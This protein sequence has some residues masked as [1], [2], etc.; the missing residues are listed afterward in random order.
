MST[1]SH[2]VLV[3]VVL[4]ADPRKSTIDIIQSVGRGQRLYQRQTKCTVIVPIHYNNLGNEHNFSPII[5]ILTAMNDF[6]GKIVE[7]FSLEERNTKVVVRKM[8]VNRIVKCSSVKMDKVKYSVSDMINNLKT[9]IMDR[10]QLSWEIKKNL[11]FKY[12][13]ENNKTPCK[14][15][16]YE[17]TRLGKWVCTQKSKITSSEDD[18][19]KELSVNSIVK[20][21]LDKYLQHKK[22]N[23]V[24]IKI[25]WNTKK[26][27]LFQYCN[28]EGKIPMRCTVYK[29]IKLGSWLDSQKMKITSS[30]D[31]LYKILSVNKFVKESLDNF[32]DPMRVWNTK[33]EQL[34]QYCNKEGKIPMRY[35]VYEDTRLGPWLDAQK[36]K[37]TSSED[38]LYKILST[39]DIVKECLD[40][41][42]QYKKEN[43]KKEKLT[44]NEYKNLLFDYTI[45][46]NKVPPK[47][48]V[49]EKY[50]IGRWLEM[51]KRK[52]TSTEDE[53]YKILSVNNI[54]K[55]SLDNYLQYK[56]EYSGKQRLSWETQKEI[57]FDYTTKFNKMPPQKK[58]VY[59]ECNIGEWISTQKKKIISSEDELYKKLSVNKIVKESLDK[60]LQYRKNNANDK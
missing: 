50:R 16:I 21:S 42:L 8:M 26:E 40:K 6:D 7:Y 56:K 37:I 23:I 30:E 38:E 4:F 13:G 11:L 22:E 59:K 14:R 44:W 31:E 19:Y 9:K 15:E 2:I 57:L 34:F 18:I 47:R 17:D 58:H 39:N 32:L 46:F 41:S 25:P 35:T 24:K 12:V 53:L 33:K 27:Q 5:R 10:G 60:Y 48:S 55:E 49:Y 45:K 54:V 3:N 36:K 43:I 1:C 29:G 51:Q 28:K 52:I 20:E